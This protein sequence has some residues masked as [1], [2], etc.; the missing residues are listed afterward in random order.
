MS[1]T[2]GKL[3]AI[4]GHAWGTPCTPRIRRQRRGRDSDGHPLGRH[5]SRSLIDES[6][7]IDAADPDDGT[8]LAS[9]QYNIACDSRIPCETTTSSERL[10][11]NKRWG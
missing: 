4:C 10:F 2:V 6:L 7:D 3:W 9:A 5:I 11:A 8:V 1:V